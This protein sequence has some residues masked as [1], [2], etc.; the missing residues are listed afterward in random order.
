MVEES[1]DDLR[2]ACSESFGDFVHLEAEINGC[3]GTDN[4]TPEAFINK[5][6]L[7]T[8]DNFMIVDLWMGLD[9]GSNELN[10]REELRTSVVFDRAHGRGATGW[11]VT[12]SGE[13]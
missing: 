3:V 10:P 13:R 8:D 9:V 5:E 2:I 12:V 6:V 4:L 7:L 11:G 1:V